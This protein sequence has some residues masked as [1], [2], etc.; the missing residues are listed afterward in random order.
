MKIVYYWMM[1]YISKIKS[2]E[3]PKFNAY[4]LVCAM[5]FANLGSL[6]VVIKYL[7][8]I[9]DNILS[10][11]DTIRL[12]IGIGV[13]VMIINYFILYK[14]RNDIE[15]TYNLVSSKKRMISKVAFWI[16]SLCSFPLFY[17]LLATINK[18]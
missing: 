9:E 13:I 14:K 8:D 12:G 18:I 2:N 17:F 5:L 11:Q 4:L 3:M 7:F 15:V 10:K 1:H 6:F 16:Y